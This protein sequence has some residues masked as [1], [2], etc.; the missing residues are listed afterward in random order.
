MDMTAR[1]D[2][3]LVGAPKCGTTA[4]H[5]YLRRHPE[6]FLP[7][8][9]EIH[10]YGSDLSG[11]A[12]QLTDGQ[13]AALF[14][15]AEKAKRVG[16]T[17]IWALYSR[18]AAAELR[19][20]V[21][22]ARIL[23]MLRNPV[24]MLYAQHS[25]LVYQ[26]IEDIASFPRALAAEADRKQGRRLPKGCFPVPRSIL[27]YREVAKY[28]AQVERYLRAFGPKQVH[29]ILMDDLKRDPQG[30]YRSVLEFLDVDAGYRTDLPVINPNKGIRSVGLRKLLHRPP[31]A[32][33]SL[34]R[35]IVPAAVRERVFETLDRWNVGVRPRRPMDEQLRLRLEEEFAPDVERLSGL[36]GRN[37][38]HWVGRRV[39]ACTHAD[40]SLRSPAEGVRASTHPTPECVRAST[41]PT[42][43][44][45]RA[46]TRPAP[47][48]NSL[49]R[50]PA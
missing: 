25:E 31:P 7:E 48:A 23:I 9:K 24:E 17:C 16:E 29:V 42:P 6:V 2:F 27:F 43:E 14:A 8:A 1:P 28:A 45:V 5:A 35:A 47:A 46:S 10:Y 44:C 19:R 13:H 49:E 40:S 50:C 36:L 34:C 11:L 41:R 26:W 30:V 39:R 33:N 37:L 15:G 32:A 12:T 38:M 21:P 22:Q 3:F 4:M 20:D 18:N